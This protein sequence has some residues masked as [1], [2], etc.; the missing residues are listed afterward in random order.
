MNRLRDFMRLFRI[1]RQCHK[2]IAA[3][4]YAWVVSGMSHAV[5]KRK[6]SAHAGDG[7]SRQQT[8]Q[9]AH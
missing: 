3:A 1:Y 2:P 6:S 4:R 7:Q 9:A 8:R 5:P